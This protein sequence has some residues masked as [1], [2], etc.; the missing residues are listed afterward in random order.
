MKSGKSKEKFFE[1]KL[2]SKG[3]EHPSKKEKSF[4]FDNFDELISNSN[5]SKTFKKKENVSIKFSFLVIILI[6]GKILNLFELVFNFSTKLLVYISQL[7]FTKLFS[8]IYFFVIKIFIVLVNILFY[9]LGIK[10]ILFLFFLYYFIV[11]PLF[12]KFDINFFLSLIPSN[13]I[14]DFLRLEKTFSFSTTSPF[15]TFFENHPRFSLRFFNKQWELRSLMRNHDTLFKTDFSFGRRW[16]LLR[17]YGQWFVNMERLDYVCLKDVYHKGVFPYDFIVCSIMKNNYVFLLFHNLSFSFFFLFSIFF[18][19]IEFWSFVLD[20]TKFFVE[21]NISYFEGKNLFLIYIINFL[22]SILILSQNF[23]IIFTYIVLFIY[24]LFEFA[25]NSFLSFF[26]SISELFSDN[27]FFTNLN[28]NIPFFIERKRRFIR[29]RKLRGIVHQNF[30]D[31]WFPRKKIN[32]VDKNFFSNLFYRGINIKHH[33]ARRTMEHLFFN[34]NFFY[35]YKHDPMSSLI[36]LLDF[37]YFSNDY[38]FN[39]FFKKKSLYFN[40]YFLPSKYKRY[41]YRPFKLSKRF[42]NFIF[43]YNFSIDQKYVDFSHTKFF[44]SKRLNKKHRIY[45]RFSFSYLHR[46]TLDL[47]FERFNRK[48]GYLFHK[49]FLFFRRLYENLAY[50]STLDFFDYRTDLVRKK[51]KHK[52][53]FNR[54]FYFSSHTNRLKKVHYPYDKFL[55]KKQV[56]GE[57][58]KYIGLKQRR[59]RRIRMFHFSESINVFFISFISIIKNYFFIISNIN[60]ILYKNFALYFSYIIC[61]FFI[62]SEFKNFLSRFYYYYNFNN[63]EKKIFFLFGKDKKVGFFSSFMY[64]FIN[65]MFMFIISLPYK[66]FFLVLNGLLIFVSWFILNIN[67]LSAKNCSYRIKIVNF[68]QFFIVFFKKC[69]MFFINGCFIIMSFRFYKIFFYS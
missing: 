28:N 60:F 56:L 27:N 45:N 7:F 18:I 1:K 17:H 33:R 62:V 65:Y 58:F 29:N 23:Y 66:I 36:F 25:F 35:F 5:F 54:G 22:N 26:L 67:L 59:K 68:M 32:A 55:Q 52:K 14:F 38:A 47:L 10:K 19:N 57:Y 8:M 69:K 42:A 11:I 44:L 50:S 2:I 15:V 51:W 37:S 3:Q 34:K 21:F 4:K 16:T 49:R 61:F 6:F 39:N 40:H 64:F 13:F 63:N 9:F 24:S 46:D 41:P 30:L 31:T 20:L 12:F 48:R 43:D 53:L